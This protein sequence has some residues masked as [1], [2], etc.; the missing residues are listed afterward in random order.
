MLLFSA[1]RLFFR[2]RDPAEVE[3]P[4]VPL[5]IGTGAAIGFLSGVTGTGGG[6][7]LTP[8]LLFCRWT[9]TKRAAAISVLFILMNSVAGLAGYVTSGQAVPRFAWLLALA[10]VGAGTVGSYLGSR[11]FPVRTISLLLATVLLIAGLK[12]VFGG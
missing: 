4:A 11:R 2:H 12:L 6:I 8:L 5:A 7:F 9:Y 3:A 1:A 10:A